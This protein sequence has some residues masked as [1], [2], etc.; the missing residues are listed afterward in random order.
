MPN[1][2]ENIVIRIDGEIDDVPPNSVFS[3]AEVGTEYSFEGVLKLNK[4]TNVMTVEKNQTLQREDFV[5]GIDRIELF[6]EN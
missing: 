6:G 3:N 1:Y 5:F 4:K 2:I